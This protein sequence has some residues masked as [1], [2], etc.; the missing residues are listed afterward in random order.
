MELT[1]DQAV[2]VIKRQRTSSSTTKEA[3]DI[4]Y[5][6]LE[7][8][9]K[10]LIEMGEEED[11]RERLVQL[12]EEVQSLSTVDKVQA[13]H[14]EMQSSVAKLGKAIDKNFLEDISKVCRK[15]KQFQKDTLH[16]VI[17]QHFYREGRFEEGDLF[18]KETG[19]DPDVSMKSEFEEMH[20]ILGS[21][22][23]QHVEPALQWAVQHRLKLNPNGLP[24]ELEFKLVRLEYMRL[25]QDE[26]R[27]P[28]LKFAKEN[29]PPH[30]K[31]RMWEISKL[32]GCLLYE[33]KLE[34]SPY[35]SIL[36]DDVWGDVRK[37][38]LQEY[39]KTVGHSSVSPLSVVVNAGAL[40][41]QPLLKL[42][43]I[44]NTA[45]LSDDNELP[46]EIPLG[47]EYVFHSIFTCP[48]SKEQCTANNPPMRLQCGHVLCKQSIQK[49][50][51]AGARPF[52]C[53]YC[54]TECLEAKCKRVHF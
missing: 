35:K 16:E 10:D 52:K 11:P 26:G 30:G 18:V 54:P 39:C 9:R 17:A 33:K 7:R 14:K 19:M 36:F 40:A 29:F 53:P 42:T 13:G 49:L 24:S 20:G 34:N 48:V 32:M 46:V 21:I 25:L 8:A 27:M 43:N 1:H 3:L 37:C 23:K 45:G 22:E 2:K 4:L 38:F 28:A 12:V 5:E 50:A 31:N 6:A 44:M 15:G 47:P 51:R 41:L